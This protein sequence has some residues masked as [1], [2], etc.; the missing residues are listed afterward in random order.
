MKEGLGISQSKKNTNGHI[1]SIFKDS[2]EYTLV[3]WE[4][5]SGSLLYYRVSNG[6]T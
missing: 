2:D 6:R 4:P 5:L 3:L 1:S